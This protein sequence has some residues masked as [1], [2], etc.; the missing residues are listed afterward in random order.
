MINYDLVIKNIYKRNFKLKLCQNSIPYNQLNYAEIQY[1]HHFLCM[2]CSN[3][4][5]LIYYEFLKDTKDRLNI[6]RNISSN[7]SCEQY[8]DWINECPL[9][10]MTCEKCTIEYFPDHNI[11]FKYIYSIVID[12]NWKYD[13]YSNRSLFRISFKK[14]NEIYKLLSKK[15]SPLLVIP[16]MEYL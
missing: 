5:S 3:D 4:I 12:R 14:F 16:I 10:F 7:H 9:R 15:M 6:P 13:F 8:F 1:E 2:L 11:D